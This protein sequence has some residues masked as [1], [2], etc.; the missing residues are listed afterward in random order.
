MATFVTHNPRPRGSVWKP[1]LLLAGAGIAALAAF[2]APRPAHADTTGATQITA[3]GV[4]FAFGYDAIRNRRD[5]GTFD[6][7][8]TKDFIDTRPTSFSY[9]KNE[10]IGA[11]LGEAGSGNLAV[12][13]NRDVTITYR[14]PGALSIGN[15]EG[16][17]R[18]PSDNL[19]GLNGGGGAFNDQ[20]EMF[21]LASDWAANGTFQMTGYV[22]V[23]ID[24]PA[25]GAVGTNQTLGLDTGNYTFSQLRGAELFTFYQAANNIRVQQSIRLRRSLARLEWTI[26]NTDTQ[27]HSVG[28]QYVTNQEIPYFLDPV[29]G[30]TTRPTRLRGNSIPDVLDLAEQRA[31]PIYRPRFVFRGYEV[32]TPPDQV[33]V[34]AI[35]AYYGGR[36]NG[37]V[38]PDVA[39]NAFPD[40]TGSRVGAGVAIYWEPQ[41]IPPN[42]TR[43]LVVYFGNGSATEN[44][45]PDYV[46]GTEAEE[47]LKYNTFNSG[48]EPIPT[49]PGQDAGRNFLTPQPFTI[50]GG[51]YSQSSTAPT[52]EVVLNNVTM[53]LTLP[54]GLELTPDV[55]NNA[56][57]KPI[58]TLRADQEGTV[59][60]SVRPNGLAYGPLAYQVTASAPPL[61]GRTVT[62]IVNV[63]AMPLKSVTT[64]DWQLLSFPFEFDPALS[65]NSDPLTIVNG[66][67]APAEADPAP[68]FELINDPL[69]SNGFGGYRRAETLKPGIAY[70]Y[71]PNFDRTVFLKGAVPVANQAPSFSSGEQRQVRLSRGWNL[72]GNPYVYDIPRG[73]LRF[74][75]LENNPNLQSFSIADAEAA[76][77]VRGA[78]F[79]YRGAQNGLY[80]FINTESDVLRPWVGYWFYSNTDAI[81]IYLPPAQIG[82]EVL[83]AV[84]TGAAGN[85]QIQGRKK[86]QGAMANRSALLARPTTEEW[87]LQLVARTQNGREDN[88]ALV[89][90]SRSA[91]NGDDARD[92][93]K[94][95][96]FRDYVYLGIARAGAGTRFAQDLQAPGGTKSWE[97]EALSDQDGKITLS[98]PNTATLPRRVR[99]KLTD[100]ETGRSVDLRRSSSL[101]VNATSNTVHRFRVTADLTPTR[102][103]AI[104][105]LRPIRS[106][107]AGYSISFDLTASASVSGRVLTLGGKMARSL[108]NGRAADSGNNSLHWDERDD[109]GAALPAGPYLVEI[110]ARGDAG[111]VVK[112]RVPVLLVR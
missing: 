103:L 61:T 96:P 63:P 10:Y 92:L 40:F 51:V 59:N 111:E 49:N 15:V 28:L 71:R 87:K 36:P 16:S 44:P 67:R 76:G 38:P 53:S 56:S 72:I 26:T 58:G 108:A 55:Q 109:K 91:K 18:T 4:L 88:A 31:N 5:D 85:A 20:G 83:G 9:V 13:Y 48:A 66:A 97:V 80:D 102:A 47:T 81:L 6:P 32:V 19:L 70:F 104:S 37:Y 43:R 68:V 54:E 57:T 89:G 27:A 95:P 107:S 93:P 21:P 42:G 74:T 77:L 64:S 98:W 24:P 50:Y 99:L 41:S 45:S 35:N 7:D 75:P 8:L 65:N 23:N 17:L 86:T 78:L 106:R 112:Q 73:F 14:I 105:N 82:S 30:A 39:L 12:K 90:V 3:N 62:R 60:W 100:L 52:E 79:F 22:A 25:P 84:P 110:T 11:V 46:V 2:A 33:L 34:T 29:R 94:P 101:T 1:G 69:S